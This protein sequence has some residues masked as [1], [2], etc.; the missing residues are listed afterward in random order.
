MSYQCPSCDGEFSHVWRCRECGMIVCDAC[1]KGGQSS[2]LGKLVRIFI[3]ILTLAISEVAR[4]GYRKI[5]QR[6]PNCGST[7]LIKI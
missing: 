5:K 2:T 4:A 6:C 1:S 3:G 7:D